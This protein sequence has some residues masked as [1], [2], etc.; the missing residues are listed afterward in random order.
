MTSIFRTGWSKYSQLQVCRF[1]AFTHN[2]FIF[3]TS[4]IVI[5][6]KWLVEKRKTLWFWGGISSLQEASSGLIAERLW[7]LAVDGR[8]RLNASNHLS[9]LM[10]GGMKRAVLINADLDRW[11]DLHPTPTTPPVSPAPNRP[12]ETMACWNIITHRRP[13]IS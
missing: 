12:E 5:F 1:Q 9:D 13:P 10:R 2:S 3:C 4:I 8:H 7:P 11:M 6:N